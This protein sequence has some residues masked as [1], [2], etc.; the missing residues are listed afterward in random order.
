MTTICADVEIDG[1]G[2]WYVATCPGCLKRI[3]ASVKDGGWWGD[4][5]CD[6]GMTW[7]FW[8]VAE[9]LEAEAE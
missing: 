8:A 4:H 6:C 3:R 2:A 1:N 9:G 7:E 5:E